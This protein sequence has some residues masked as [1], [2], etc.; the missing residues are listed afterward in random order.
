MKQFAL[1]AA[2]LIALAGC[3]KS[4]SNISKASSPSQVVAAS[5]AVV[6]ADHELGRKIYNFRCYYCHGYSG[7]AKTLAASFV[8]PRPVDFTHTSLDA[9]PRER[10]LASIKSGRPG[11]AMMSFEH[12]LQPNE[13]AAVADFV[14]QEFMINKAEN[15][16]YHTVA[17][18]W[19][20]HERYKAAYP[21]ALGELA[22]GTPWEKLTP[23]QADGKRLF[24]TSCISCHD[25]GT[26]K[27]TEDKVQW[28]SYPLSYPRNGYSPGDAQEEKVDAMSSATPYLIH[29]KPPKITDLT[30]MEKQGEVLFQGNCSFCHAADGTAKN[31]IGSFMQPHPRNL[32]DPAAMVGMTK[33]RFRKVIN[34]GL[35]GTS[36]PAWKSVL[37][38]QDI[39]SVI[40][41]VSRV[42]HPLPPE[43]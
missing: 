13:I 42:F 8:T 32:T 10:M 17:N 9:L 22:L 35:P 38:E 1:L 6:T 12:I 27:G 33:T 16:R 5:G 15:T 11:T 31:W 34:E 2:M 28:A 26:A 19:L 14:R 29:E 18:G 40:A 30:A 4:D 39:E 25:R 41:Y 7:D 3:S 21:F 20:N 24:L 36:M 43:S 37:S 23:E